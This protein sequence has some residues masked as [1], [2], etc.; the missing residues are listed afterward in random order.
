MPK[1]VEQYINNATCQLSTATTGVCC[2]PD[3]I[4]ELPEN[5]GLAS[6]ERIANGNETAVF[7]FPWMALLM[8]RNEDTDEITGDCGGALI[9]DR[10]VITAAHCLALKSRGRSDTKLYVNTYTK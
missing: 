5:C 4:F 8:Y 6:S 9:S 1:T 7:E 2:V 3:K 10:Y